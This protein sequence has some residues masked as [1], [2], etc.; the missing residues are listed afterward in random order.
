MITSHGWKRGK[1]LLVMAEK[2]KMITSNSWKIGKWLLEIA[3]K[4]GK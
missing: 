3:E 2:G 4:R 1:W